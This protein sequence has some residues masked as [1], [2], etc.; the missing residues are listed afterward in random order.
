MPW[1]SK[2]CLYCSLLYPSD[3]SSI[4]YK[5]DSQIFPELVSQQVS[6]SVNDKWMNERVVPAQVLNLNLIELGTLPPPVLP[7]GICLSQIRWVEKCWKGDLWKKIQGLLLKE[8]EECTEERG[9][10]FC[11]VI[12]PSFSH[13]ACMLLPGT[14]FISFLLLPSLE[15]VINSSFEMPYVFFCYLSNTIH[16][17]ID[18]QF[19]V[20]SHTDHGDVISTTQDLLTVGFLFCHFFKKKKKKEKYNVVICSSYLMDV[21]KAVSFVMVA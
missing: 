21:E 13:H 7:S 8:R 1:K 20:T 6:E 17:G 15:K 3:L 4:W 12:P 19:L 10:A 2:L 14:R 9:R 5:E 16:I 11:P 18:S